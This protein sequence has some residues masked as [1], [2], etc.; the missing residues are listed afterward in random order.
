[1]VMAPQVPDMP[2]NEIVFRRA[3]SARR[4]LLR[5]SV[6]A[7]VVAIVAVAVGKKLGSLFFVIA[8]LSGLAAVGSA[9]S[10]VVQSSFRTVLGPDGISARGYVRRTI[11]WSQ[12]VGFQVRGSAAQQVAPEKPGAGAADVAGPRRLV[13]GYGPRQ[14]PVWSGARG[15]RTRPPTARACIAVLRTHGRP[16][17]LPAPVVAGEEGDDHFTDDLRQLEQWRQH[18]GGLTNPAALR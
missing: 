18:Y 2:G 14:S 3:R 8:G 4:R 15:R 12:I 6:T 9:A 17:R 5:R 13:A 7:L 16:V 11:P 1:M 10:Y